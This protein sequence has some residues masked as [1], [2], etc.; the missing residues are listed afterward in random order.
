MFLTA[1]EVDGELYCKLHENKF[2]VYVLTIAVPITIHKKMLS[3]RTLKKLKFLQHENVERVGE[4]V[5]IAG[6]IGESTNLRSRKNNYYSCV[7]RTGTYSCFTER[8][9][10]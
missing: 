1:A 9:H 8:T 4:I 5:N 10:S 2:A 7:N 3:D 6:K